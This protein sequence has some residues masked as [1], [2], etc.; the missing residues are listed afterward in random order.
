MYYSLVYCFYHYFHLPII[1][2][3]QNKELNAHRN[4]LEKLVD[5]RTKDLVIAKE[6]DTLQS[7]DLGSYRILV[8]EDEA[9]SMQLITILL[10][11]TKCDIIQAV[12]GLE[13]FELIENGQNPDLILMDLKMPV[14]DGFDATRK[15]KEIQDIPI[16][17]LSAYV[18]SEQDALQ[19]GCNAF[20]PKPVNSHYL[21]FHL[22]KYPI[23]KY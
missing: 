13:A 11:K 21:A 20:I 3:A 7:L 22:K 19:A 5:K 23:D 10:Q 2:E 6:K 18:S 15:I 12:N 8:A 1:I 4:K 17:A 9:D 16:I 14:M